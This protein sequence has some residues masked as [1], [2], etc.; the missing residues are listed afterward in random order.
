MESFEIQKSNFFSFIN[1]IAP[2]E[3]IAIIAHANCID[4]MASAIFMVEL[5]KK[6][7]P[8]LPSPLI[9]FLHY[10]AGTLDS[11]EG[12]FKKEGINKVC[13][14]DLNVDYNILEEFEK[15]RSSFDVLFVDHHPLN[16]KL[17]LS[18]QVI[19]THKDDCTA[20]VL[21]R[22][23]EGLID[24]KKGSWLACVAAVSE[25]SYKK[26]ENVNF[27]QKYYPSFT[28]DAIEHSEILKVVNKMGSLVIYYAEDCLA[29][30]E[31]ILHDKR[32]KIEE[33]HKK[34]SAE[35]ERALKDFEQNAESVFDRKL[36]FYFLQSKYDIDSKLSTMLSLKYKGATIIV[37]SG[38]EKDIL[39]V[40]SRNNG[41]NLAYPM[42]EMI[43]AGIK[44]LENALGGGH[45]AA[46]GGSFLRKDLATFKE[47]VKEFVKTWIK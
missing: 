39:H 32:E 3:K 19:K 38:V 1:R 23:G 34:V 36:Y 17:R 27:I 2:K 25:F 44:G 40:S 9:H 29:A 11:L 33:A 4:G 37:C 14:L 18:D 42:H 46:T 6:K 28:V 5:L 16:P 22:F 35:I 8:S 30:Y 41:D 47:Q 7:Y 31:I 43:R 21:Y 10:R 15:F 26:E 12:P 13:I 20:L 24:E 45:A